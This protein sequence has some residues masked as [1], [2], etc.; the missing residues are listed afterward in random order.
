MRLSRLLTSLHTKRPAE[1]AP[2]TAHRRTAVSVQLCRLPNEI[3]TRKSSLS[4][5]SVR[6]FEEMRWRL[7]HELSARGA[8]HRDPKVD[9]E[10]SRRPPTHATAAD[11]VA[12]AEQLAKNTK[13]IVVW[14]KVQRWE[15]EAS[16]QSLDC[17]NTERLPCS[18]EFR[19]ECAGGDV[20]E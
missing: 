7:P 4:R 8:E 13:A 20:A 12:V 6:R 14:R 18:G 15:Q 17:D 2:A 16:A 5:S 3:H 19:N 1:D 11:D 9:P 10:V